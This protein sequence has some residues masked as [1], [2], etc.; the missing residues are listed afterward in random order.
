MLLHIDELGKTEIYKIISQSVIPRPIAWIVTEEEGIV[1]IAPFSYFIP[2]SSEPATLLVS[3]GHKSDGTPKDTLANLRKH[4]KCVV[5]MVEKNHL[6]AM[7]YTSKPLGHEESEAETF[8]IQTERIEAEYPPMVAD[9]PVAFFCS[10]MQEV[11]IGGS[12][13]PLVLRVHSIH[14][15][16]RVLSDAERLSIAYDPVA[17]VG[18]AYALCGATIDPP[19]IS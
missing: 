14:I 17:R 9:T 10:L 18:K 1:N 4:G 15:A 8:G 3:V 12:T 16:D 5:C 19:H 11:P 7:H 13:V 2:L 6:E